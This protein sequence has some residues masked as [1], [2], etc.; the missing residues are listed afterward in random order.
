MKIVLYYPKIKSIKEVDQMIILDEMYDKLAMIPTLIQ[1]MAFDNIKQYVSN[2]NESNINEYINL[3]RDQISRLDY[4]IPLFDYATKNIYLI[5]KEDTYQ[6]V[7]MYNYRF[8]DNQILKLLNKTIDDL[9][10]IKIESKTGL[11]PA[12]NW[13]VKYIQ[14]ITKNL[15][16]LSNFNQPILK[17]TYNYTFLNTNPSSRELTSCIKPSYLP[18]QN[19]QSPYYTK[20]ELVSMG[21][22]LGLIPNKQTSPWSFT[23]SNLKN[24]CTKLSQYEI[25][26]QMLIY[27]QLYILYN[28]AKAYVQY[29]SLFG[30]Y[31]FNSYLRNAK[32]NIDL[33]LNNHID[34][35]LKLIQQTPAFDNDYEV[36]R[37]IENDDYLNHLSIGDIYEER[38]FISTTR[39]P[40]YSSKDNVFGFILIKIKLKKNMPGIALLMESYSNYPHEQEVLLVPSQLKLVEINNDFKYYHWNKL[41]EK[42]I[43]KKY[44]FE[45]VKPISYSIKT[46]IEKY[47]STDSFIPEL[48]FYKLNYDGQTTNERMLNFFNSLPKLNLR[49]TF[50]SIIGQTQYKFYAYF[51]TQNKVYAKF[52]FLQKEDEQNKMLGDEIYLTIQNPSNGQIELIIEIRNI[53]SVNYYHRYSGLKNFIIDDDLVYWLSGLAKSLQIQTVIIHGNYSSYAHVVENIFDQTK[54]KSQTQTNLLENFKI[55]S[56]IDNPDANILNLY[57]ADINT[58]CVDLVEYIFNSSKRFFH[59]DYIQRQIPLHMIDKLKTLQ[60]EYLYQTYGSKLH[61][62]EYL[63]KIFL[64]KSDPKMT[65]IEF[66]KLIHKTYPYLILKLQNLII[67]SYP[68][69]S[70]GPWH[71]YYVLKPFEYLFEKKI[72][73]FIPSTNLDKIDELIKNLEAEVKFI[74]DN[75]FRQI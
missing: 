34:N 42:K 29:Y 52:F 44:I 30:S 16:F 22:N 15:N 54:S 13:V 31:Y 28:N 58:Y 1:L 18:Y 20:S 25:T 73:N 69:N 27:N 9:K 10:L 65:V 4:K 19:Y 72:I 50:Y 39:N 59:K 51:L 41:A 24:I 12:T 8:P 40:F 37:F 17:E 56:D 2:P 26:T 14:K 5:D 74:H 7:T 21:L 46:Y 71:F 23:D 3:I 67:L 75:K 43:I 6:K 38:S 11:D 55:I 45:Y 36:Y 49:R 63:Y 61:G 48:N 70:I 32:S 68:S 66:Y 62:Y 60:F 53:I 33:D 57:T 47:P 35:F 64:K